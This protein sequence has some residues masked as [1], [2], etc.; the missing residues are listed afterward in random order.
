MSDNTVLSGGCLCGEVRYTA[1]AVPFAADYCHCGM[2]RK[3][4]GAPVSAW[5]DFK[6]GQL[7][8]ESRE[9]LAE[10]ASSDGFRRGFCSQ[11]GSTLTYRS[12]NHPEY[13]SLAISSLDSADQVQPTYHIY[14]DDQLPWFDI[15]DNCRRYPQAQK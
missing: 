5:M 11:C 10:Y 1:Q 2:C 6:A 9:R 13:V 7:H 8:W 4:T 14:T 3:S 15:N 12:V